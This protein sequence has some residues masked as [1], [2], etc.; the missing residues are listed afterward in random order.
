MITIQ[1]EQGNYIIQVPKNAAL[2]QGFFDELKFQLLAE[3]WKEESRFFSFAQ[4]RTQLPS[5]QAISVWENQHCHTSL[6]KWQT[7][8]ITGL[9]L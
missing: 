6:K 5:N 1:E 9:L 7:N 2:Q 3:N 8:P 4:Q